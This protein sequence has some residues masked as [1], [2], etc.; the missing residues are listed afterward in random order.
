MKMNHF[1]YYFLI[2]VFT[3]LWGYLYLVEVLI[4]AEFDV[5]LKVKL[6]NCCWLL[7]FK[8]KHISYDYDDNIGHL[9]IV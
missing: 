7:V 2:L 9:V 8:A 1:S 5:A 3:H 6:E 4:A